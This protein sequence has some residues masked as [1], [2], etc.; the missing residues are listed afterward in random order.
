VTVTDRGRLGVRNS[1]EPVGT[2]PGW[3]ASRHRPEFT[4]GD[5]PQAAVLSL[6]LAH[7]AWEVR[8]SR[9]DAVPAGTPVSVT[10]WAL[11]AR[12]PADL[13]STVEGGAVALTDGALTSHLVAVTGFDRADLVRAPAGTAYGDWALVPR[14]RGTLAAPGSLG[15]VV[16]AL[17]AADPGP[18]PAVAVDGPT[19]TAVFADGRRG[20][21]TLGSDVPR[22]EW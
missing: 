10:G 2:G 8:I 1:F 6:V 21:V 12:G 20:R 16:A 9:F 11:A 18:A 5:L 13:P 19:V 4:G 15:V 14:L 17:S 7:G 22:V 3:A